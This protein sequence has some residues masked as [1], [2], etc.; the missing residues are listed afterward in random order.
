MVHGELG[1]GPLEIATLHG[2][3]SSG[4]MAL[5]NAYLQVAIGEKRTAI[6]VAS[7]FASRFFKSS[8]FDEMGTVA[9]EGSL[10]LEAAFLRFMLSDGAGAVVIQDEPKASGISLRIEAI[11]KS[12]DQS[13]RTSPP[14]PPSTASAKPSLRSCRTMRQRLPP[15]ARRI[16]ISLRRAVPRASS[17]LARL[18]H[19]TSNTTTAIP[20]S[21]G[22]MTFIPLSAVGLLLIELR[23]T[24]AV[25]NV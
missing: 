19:A 15:S 24:G 21:N 4:M 10:P 12:D 14:A 23:D 25:V 7:E 20:I 1:Y 9:E 18:R 2:I 16:A 22:A 11:R 6:S 17:M 8:R 3:C 13:P 5:K